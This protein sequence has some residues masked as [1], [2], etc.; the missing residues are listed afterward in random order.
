MKHIFAIFF[1][2]LMGSVA[3]GQ[4]IIQESREKYLEGEIVG[5]TKQCTALNSNAEAIKNCVDCRLNPSKPG[6]NASADQQSCKAEFDKWQ[7]LAPAGEAACDS[8]SDAPGKTCSEQIS[9]CKNQIKAGISNL[10]TGNDSLT[11]ITNLILGH[12]DAANKNNTGPVK[13]VNAA[14]ISYTNDPSGNIEKAKKALEENIK[15]TKKDILEKRKEIQDRNKEQAKEE[16]EIKADQ[17]KLQA[18]F[19]KTIQKIEVSKREKYT[20]LNKR[21]QEHGTNIRLKNTEIIKQQ[22]ALDKMKFDHQK[23]MLQFAGK[24]IE[25]ACKAQLVKAKNCVVRVNSGEKLPDNDSCKAYDMEVGGGSKGTGEAKKKLKELHDAC[26]EQANSAVSTTKYDYNQK[27]QAQQLVIQQLVDDIDDA[28][29]A[30]ESEKAT[31]E[32]IAKEADAEKSAEEKSLQQQMTNFSDKLTKLVSQTKEA[33]EMTTAA[34]KDLDDQLYE[35]MS[36]K[37]SNEMGIATSSKGVSSG[38]ADAVVSQAFRDYSVA[39][40]ARLA[41]ATSCCGDQKVRDTTNK[42]IC[43][44]LETSSTAKSKSKKATGTG[45]SRTRN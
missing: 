16:A 36:I 29:K 10:D 19:D 30:M 1:I 24:K 26:F 23:A 35:L 32:T 20:E 12:M 43:D 13:N 6:C 17:Q 7:T 25:T 38:Y 21:L 14:C 34:I 3:W 11:D 22:A 4:S 28:T 40:N 42:K 27:V 15:E 45:K 33:N 5:Y 9:Y 8:I 39:E 2:L 44:K 31:Q 37:A 41:A 18:E